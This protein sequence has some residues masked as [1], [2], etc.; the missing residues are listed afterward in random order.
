MK[1]ISD[2]ESIHSVSPFYLI[3]EKVD[4]NGEKKMEIDI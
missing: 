4:E 2:F 3:D 1:S